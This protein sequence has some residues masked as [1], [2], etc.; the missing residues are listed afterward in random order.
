MVYVMLADGFEMVEALTPIDILRRANIPVTTISIADKM[1][2]SSHGVSVQAE[3]TLSDTRK[4]NIKKD[5]DMLILPGGGL[6]TQNLNACA[7]IH[8]LIQYCVAQDKYVAAICAAPSVI[9]G[10]MGL[11]QGKE[12]TCYPG[13]EEGMTGA[14]AKQE[15]F[16]VAGKIIT[17]RAAGTA[18]DFA[19][20]LCEIL[21]GK[22]TAD[23][24]ASS[25]CYA[26]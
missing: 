16:C 4:E 14:I 18:M 15:P 25:I 9:L 10:G 23:E 20:E 7:Q 11:L 12:A 26:R 24:I 5:I 22:A 1:V 2:K 19:L 13:M 21:A 8:E 17:G 3:D 6:G